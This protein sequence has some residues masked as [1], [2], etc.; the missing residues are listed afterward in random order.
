MENFFKKIFGNVPE[1][2]KQISSH[3][4]T[5]TLEKFEKKLEGWM[6]DAADQ[7]FCPDHWIKHLSELDEKTGKVIAFEGSYP[8]SD[9]SNYRYNENGWYAKCDYSGCKNEVSVPFEE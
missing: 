8:T 4:E 2:K 7:D 1:H 5:P 9:M 3:E 6:T